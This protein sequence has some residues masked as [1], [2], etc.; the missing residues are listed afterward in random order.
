L[1][2][3]GEVSASLAHELRNMIGAIQSGFRLLQDETNVIQK[4]VITQELA[5]SISRLEATLRNLLEFTKKYSINKAHVSVKELIE[6]QYRLCLLQDPT[7]DKVTFNIEGEATI[8][9]DVNL[10]QEQSGIY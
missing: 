2:L 8:P 9:L 5:S 4:K 10:F 6:E 3:L 7:G 1:A